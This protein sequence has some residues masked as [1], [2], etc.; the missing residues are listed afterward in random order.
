MIVTGINEEA[1]E[2]DIHEAFA[3]HGEIKNLHLN[4]DRRTGFVKARLAPPQPGGS[5]TTRRPP[6]ARPASRVGPVASQSPPAAGGRTG[7]TGAAQP[8]SP[9]LLTTLPADRGMRSSSTSLAR[10]RRPPSPP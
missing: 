3:E 8:A 9:S 6:P 2:D 1:Q 10:R 5:G 7:R 4:L